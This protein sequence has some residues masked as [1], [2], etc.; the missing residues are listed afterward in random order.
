MKKRQAMVK[1][2]DDIMKKL[3]FSIDHGISTKNDGNIIDLTQE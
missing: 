1:F 3:Q 2:G